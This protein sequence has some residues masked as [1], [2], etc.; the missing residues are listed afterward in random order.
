MLGWYLLALQLLATM[1][2]PAPFPVGDLS[3]TWRKTRKDTHDA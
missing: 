2:I 3:K 1:G